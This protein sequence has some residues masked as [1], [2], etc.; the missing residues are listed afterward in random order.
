MKIEA[1][2]DSVK[3]TKQ[4]P[5]YGNDNTMICRMPKMEFYRRL[6]EWQRG[7]L[8]QDAFDNLT[9]DEREFLLSGYTPQVWNELFKEKVK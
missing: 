9:A 2:N 4:C 8:I 1:S 5:L 7:A 3:V 6:Y